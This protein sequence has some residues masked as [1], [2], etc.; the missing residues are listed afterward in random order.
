MIVL[1]ALSLV[2]PQASGD[3]LTLE[4]ALQLAHAQRATIRLAAAELSRARAGV[5]VAGTI[6]NPIGGYSYTEDTPRQHVSLE[7]SL[8]WLLTRGAD[9]AAGRAELGRSRA[10]STQAAADLSAEVRTAFYG[11][12]AAGELEQLTRAQAGLAD[13]LV[14]I[15]KARFARGDIPLLEQEQLTLEAVRAAQRHARAEEAAAVARTHLT[16]ALG[17]SHLDP[18]VLSGSLAAG[19]GEGESTPPPPVSAPTPRLLAAQYDSA[20]AAHRVRRAHQ[21]GAPLPTVL[22]GAD[23]DDPTAAHTP[24]AVIGFS[25]P[26]P[27]WQHGSG[28]SAVAQAEADRSS[29]LLAET[30]GAEDQRLS[31]TALRLRYTESRALVARDSLL[32]LARRVRNR[33]TIAYQSGESAITQLL[34]ALRA[35]RDVAAEAVDDLLT[36]QEAKAAW[37]QVRGLSQ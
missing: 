12:L 20:A 1:V 6:P 24:L 32:P 21:A 13:S 31:E 35:E 8:D 18:F 14:S 30:R 29:A 34:D 17:L 33:A 3:S 28:A 15:A 19:L 23:W 11:A 9:R 5:R 2:M 4:R 10:D 27:V 36:W 22:L 16:R 37:N 7:Q 25:L 26:L